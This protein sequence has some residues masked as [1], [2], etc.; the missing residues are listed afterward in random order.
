LQPPVKDQQ[1]WEMTLKS[2][3][4]HLPRHHGAR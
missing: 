2:Y 3:H 1:V 4:I